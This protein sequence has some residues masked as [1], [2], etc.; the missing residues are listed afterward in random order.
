MNEDYIFRQIFHSVSTPYLLL[1]AD[2]DRTIADVNERYLEATGLKRDDL[3]GRS[4]LEFLP[5]HPNCKDEQ[6]YR[7]IFSSV[8]ESI[9]I[10]ENNRIIDCNDM[11]ARLFETA[12]E[13][14]IGCD[15]LDPIYHFECKENPFFHYLLSASEGN[16]TMME[17]SLVL[18]KRFHKTKILEMTLS[19][20]GSDSDKLILIARDIT[21]RVEQEKLFKM[22]ARQAQLG[23]MIS[24]IAHQ[25]RQPLA[26]INAI[27]AQIRLK[28]LMKEEGDPLLIDDLTRIEQQCVHLS[29]TI[30][31][32]RDLS[33]PN[34]EKE[35][36]ILSQL[37]QQAIHLLDHTF[38][39]SNIDVSLVIDEEIE[40]ITFYNEV[41]QVLITLLKNSLD[42]AQE[43]RLGFCRIT[44]RIA[45]DGGYGTIAVHD[46]AGGIAPERIPKLFTP[47]FTTKNQKEGTGLG[48]YM[49]KMI[50]EEHC[51]GLLEVSSEGEETLFRIKLP[52]R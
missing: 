26:I 29:Q 46:T 22:Q 2:P 15:I 3:I 45:W 48:L 9:L 38:K 47:Y 24:M 21:E 32:Y 39:N 11:A 50:I 16:T 28:E 33:N 10:L 23:E 4:V 18:E 12:R 13:E 25:W 42:A 30:S 44:L 14:L 49:S 20:F 19:P 7:T 40:L 1:H 17:C 35:P 51:H 31:D 27:A 34:K 43:N 37:A 6:L 5:D 36:V 8:H 52:G 41:L